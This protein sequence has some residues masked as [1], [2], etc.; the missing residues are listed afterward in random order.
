MADDVAA[1]RFGGGAKRLLL[2]RVREAAGGLELSADGR[3]SYG[4]SYGALDETAEADLLLH[5]VDGSDADPFGQIQA[6]REVLSGIGAHYPHDW[7][8]ENALVLGFIVW[9]VVRAGMGGVA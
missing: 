7:W 9:L 6:V 3:F 8:L 1:Q 2:A 4:L 5:V